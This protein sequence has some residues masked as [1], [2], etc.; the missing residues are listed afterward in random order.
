MK[1]SLFSLALLLILALGSA[2]APAQPK[3]ATIDLEKVFDRYYKTKQADAVL[4]ERAADFEKTYKGYLDEYEKAN[5]EFKKLLDSANDQ[6]VAADERERRKK[7]AEAKQIELRQTEQQIRKYGSDSQENLSKEKLRKRDTIL[8]ELTEVIV[9]KAKA[10]SYTLVIDTAAKTINNT[11]AVLY[12][13]GE[14]DLSEEVLREVNA[15][16]PAEL[17]KPTDGKEDAKGSSKP[18]KP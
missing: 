18:D 3:I 4:K 14:Y 8:R 11:P 1:T 2:S 10:S 5:E 17:L 7:Q 16:A 6:A 12:S 15:N 13:N 9:R